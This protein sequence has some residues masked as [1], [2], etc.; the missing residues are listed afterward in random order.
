MWWQI[1]LY[2]LGGI[3]VLYG[4]YVLLA[5]LFRVVVVD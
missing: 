2:I 5:M 1:I 4:A 3:A